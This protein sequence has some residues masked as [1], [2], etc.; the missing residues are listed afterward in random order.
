MS[1]GFGLARSSDG[2]GSGAGLTGASLQDV[3]GDAEAR[4]TS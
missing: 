3:E 1:D 2:V 4:G